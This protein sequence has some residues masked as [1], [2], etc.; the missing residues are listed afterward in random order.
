MPV[1]YSVILASDDSIDGEFNAQ[2]CPKLA[3]STA[4]MLNEAEPP[5][6]A[7][8]MNPLT[9]LSLSISIL[10]DPRRLI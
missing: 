6:V 4:D 7:S 10:D 8:E 1:P 3:G 5:S 9:S 2:M